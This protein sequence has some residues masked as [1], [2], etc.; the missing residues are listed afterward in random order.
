VPEGL[1]T[2]VDVPYPNT[3]YKVASGSKF[4]T[5]VTTKYYGIYSVDFSR[6]LANT[7]WEQ[8]SRLERMGR[9]SNYFGIGD[10]KA[11][12]L[13]TGET[14]TLQ[15]YD[16]EHDELTGTYGEKA[17]ATFGMKDLMT[18]SRSMNSGNTNS[19]G[20]IASA[21]YIWMKD[22]LYTSLPPELKAVIKT[23][24]KKTSLGSSP[25]VLSVSAMDVFLFSEMECRG[26]APNSGVGEGAQYPIFTDDE[27]RIKHPHETST[28]ANWWLRSHTTAGAQSF[29]ATTFQGAAV[30]QIASSTQG[31]CFGFCV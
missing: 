22:S 2:K 21:L 5:V 25:A 3:E 9:L 8:I 16:F 13:A 30:S 23:V 14:L 7:T 1:T 31:I 15:I 17:N 26:S 4:R 29:C 11:I 18:T 20:F 27:S 12:T 28:N 6:I 24:D 10:E 19:G